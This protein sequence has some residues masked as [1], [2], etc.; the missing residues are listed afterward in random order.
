MRI[1]KLILIANMIL[2]KT[3][4]AISLETGGFLGLQFND[5]DVSMFLGHENYSYR[6]L[7]YP[8]KM[9]YGAKLALGLSNFYLTSGFTFNEYACEFHEEVT[10]GDWWSQILHFY[11]FTTPLQLQ[12]R[13]YFRNNKFGHYEGMGCSF[14]YNFKTY[15]DHNIHDKFKSFVL[16]GEIVAGM[17]F[18]FKKLKL[19]PG[20]GLRRTF[21]S[22]LQKLPRW[23]TTKFRILSFYVSIG[24]FYQIIR[25]KQV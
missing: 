1:L 6:Y 22:P 13:G 21:F 5:E 7:E 17:H 3:V 14:G 2:F 23:D 15:D 25:V 24:I 11:Y 8:P 9:Q 16:F 4:M 12:Y 18:S 19:L 10:E 20:I